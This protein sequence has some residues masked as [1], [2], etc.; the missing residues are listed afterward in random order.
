MENKRTIGQIAP[1]KSV[2]WSFRLIENACKLQHMEDRKKKK[3][4][5]SEI[6]NECGGKLT[7]HCEHK[8]THWGLKRATHL[9][10]HILGGG[11]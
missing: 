2:I 11:Q 8:A 5:I 4:Q 6:E 7:S 3:S 9:L 10:C 1:M